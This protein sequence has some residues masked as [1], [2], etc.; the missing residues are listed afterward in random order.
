MAVSVINLNTLTEPGFPEGAIYI[1]RAHPGRRLAASK[2]ANP[3]PL[4]DRNS[5][6]ERKAILEQYHAWLWDQIQSRAI[7]VQDLQALDGHAL[8]CFCA[9]QPCHGM[10]LER[11]VEW[12]M[13]KTLDQDWAGVPNPIELPR[14]RTLS[15][16][17]KPRPRR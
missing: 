8:A 15:D 6:S 2:F 12:A 14:V 4:R 11:A 10:V 7:T 17:L 13:D 5:D 3:F 1:G 9:P 16:W